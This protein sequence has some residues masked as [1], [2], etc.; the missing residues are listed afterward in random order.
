[1]D[2]NKK[3]DEMREDLINSTAELIK[4]KSLEGEAKEG[5]PFGEDPAKALACALDIAK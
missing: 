1:M 5:M 3:I 4:I 2:I